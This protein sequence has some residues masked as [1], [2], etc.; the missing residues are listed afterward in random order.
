M[1]EII[2]D[3]MVQ[4]MP[5]F[6]VVM[7]IIFSIVEGMTLGLTSIW[8]ACAS[9]VALLLSLIHVH[10]VIQG[11]VFLILSLVFVVYTR[12]IAKKYLK[13]GNV[14]TNVD[15]LIGKRGVIVKEIGSYNT[16]QVKVQGQIWTAKS[17]DFENLKCGDEVE[18]D[19]VE[20]VKLI[21]K[22]INDSEIS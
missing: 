10:I 14:K 7:I 11:V 8:F 21:V 1:P 15:A 18:V 20:G 5:M 17:P 12:P 19:G 13:I 16:G 6:W 22:K 4:I 2:M 9:V 3:K